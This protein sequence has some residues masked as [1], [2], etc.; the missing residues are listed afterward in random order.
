M[1]PRKQ[2]PEHDLVAI[3]FTLAVAAVLLD[4]ILSTLRF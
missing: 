1:D 2:S 4:L 3:S